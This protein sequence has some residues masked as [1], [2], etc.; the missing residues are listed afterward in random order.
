MKKSSTK[1]KGSTSYKETA[2]GIIPR[3]NL[4]KLELEGTKKGLEYLHD[5]IK[6][7]DFS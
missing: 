2:F 5:L 7:M 1:P 3:S 6:Q 4:L